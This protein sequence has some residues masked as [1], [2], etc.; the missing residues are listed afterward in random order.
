MIST[1]GGDRV[2]LLAMTVVRVWEFHCIYA[3]VSGLRS[4]G[5][6][7]HIAAWRRIFPKACA[8]CY[9]PLPWFGPCTRGVLYTSPTPNLMNDTNSDVC[10]AVST[11]HFLHIWSL[12]VQWTVRFQLPFDPHFSYWYHGNGRSRL[13]HAQICACSRKGH[14]KTR[15]PEFEE[16]PCSDLA[17]PA[18]LCTVHGKDKRVQITHSLSERQLASSSRHSLLP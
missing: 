11:A 2:S 8:V 4:S 17:W 18:L 9:S 5:L 15:H 3:G 16:P 1:H 12:D 13:L 10:P 6:G 7:W 14:A